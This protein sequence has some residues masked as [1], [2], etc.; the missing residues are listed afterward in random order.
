MILEIP[1]WCIIG[2]TI[3]W[4][5]PHI[6]GRKWTRE[7]IISYGMDGFFHQYPNCPIYYSKFSEYGK[8]IKELI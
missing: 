4:N 2:K 7:K 5:A 8:T 6:T 3:L 1:N